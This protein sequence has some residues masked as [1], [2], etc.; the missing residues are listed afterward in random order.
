MFRLSG[1]DR[2]SILETSVT[3][4]YDE[5]YEFPCVRSDT[6]ISGSGVLDE[7]VLNGGRWENFLCC[8]ICVP[9]G[10]NFGCDSRDNSRV[11]SVLSN[12]ESLIDLAGFVNVGS[13]GFL[14]TLC[15][16]GLTD[17]VVF[18]RNSLI[19]LISF[20]RYTLSNL[21]F[22]SNAMGLIAGSLS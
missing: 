2:V 14:L 9:I 3:L 8:V 19:S 16:F 1:A 22:L 20:G 4:S 18:V 5:C 10:C 7:I 6:A 12:S 17:L 15:M 11:I 13:V 21:G